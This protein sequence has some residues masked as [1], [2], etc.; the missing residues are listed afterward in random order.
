MSTHFDQF[1]YLFFCFFVLNHKAPVHIIIMLRTFD[2]FF[3]DFGATIC[4]CV[5]NRNESCVYISSQTAGLIS[6]QRKRE[7]Y[8]HLNKTLFKGGG[9][10]MF[11]LKPQVSTV[12]IHSICLIYCVDP[13]R[14]T[15]YP[16]KIRSAISSPSIIRN[17]V[18]PAVLPSSFGSYCKDVIAG[19][20]FSSNELL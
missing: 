1:F 18:S 6:L 7:P 15:S 17:N 2:K 20:L 8:H 14:V 13:F 12:C 4:A 11:T 19:R 9:V 10:F 16:N 3:P 5:S